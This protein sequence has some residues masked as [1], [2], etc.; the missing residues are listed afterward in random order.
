M[1][2]CKVWLPDIVEGFFVF[3]YCF[4]VK[5]YALIGNAEIIMRIRKI[6][7]QAQRFFEKR[8]SLVECLFAEISTAEI[9]IGPCFIRLFF[10]H[11]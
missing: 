5:P 6:G 10:Y 4:I 3:S 8:N 7:V 2:L 11:I 9:V 1:N